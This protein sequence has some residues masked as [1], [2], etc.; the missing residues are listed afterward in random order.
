[1]GNSS[2]LK[3]NWKNY[4]S[5]AISPV[6]LA[7]RVGVNKTDSLAVLRGYAD[8]SAGRKCDLWRIRREGYTLYRRLA[9]DTVDAIEDW[10]AANQ[11]AYEIGYNFALNGRGS[12]L[13]KTSVKT[14]K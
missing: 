11:K 14:V 6:Q 13:K 2:V 1:M 9:H 7:E 12:I 8:A 5:A 3:I 10:I 4:N